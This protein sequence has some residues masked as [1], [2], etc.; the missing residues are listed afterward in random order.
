MSFQSQALMGQDGYFVEN[1]KKIYLKTYP[2]TAILSTLVYQGKNFVFS[3][4]HAAFRCQSKGGRLEFDAQTKSIYFTQEIPSVKY[5][6]FFR[7]FIRTFLEEVKSWED[8]FFDGC[9]KNH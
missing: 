5:Y 6:V 8:F 3:E 9:R 2:K 1:G 4:S 7:V